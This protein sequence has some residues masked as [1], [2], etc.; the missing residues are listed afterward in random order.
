MS[1]AGIAY[2]SA[3][4]A[5]SRFESGALRPTDLLEA[6]IQRVEVANPLVNAFTELWLDEARDAAAHADARY[7]R[8]DARP[9][10]GV[11]LAVKDSTPLAGKVHTMGSA[12][13]AGNVAERTH[14][15]L[16]R[17]ID[18]GVVMIGRTTM[19]EF[20]EAGNCYTPLWGV[21]RNPWNLHYGPGGSSSGA[22]A[23]LAAGMATI[24][25]GS[26][27][28]GSS[29]I[30]ASCCGVYGYKPP[31][32]RNP[33]TYEGSFDPYLQ[34]GP[35]ARTAADIALM[36]EIIA[37]AS[38]EDIGTLRDTV[39]LPRRSS[40]PAG[41]RIAYS[42][43]LGY[44]NVDAEVRAAFVSTLARLRALGCELVEV[45]LPWTEA[46]YDA[47][48]VMNSIKGTAARRVAAIPDADLTLLS[49]Y[50]ADMIRR[51]TE[52]DPEDVARAIELHVAMYQNL[53]PILE[54]SKVFL[55]PT[56]AVPSIP[57]TQSPLNTDWSIN[58]VPVTPIEAEAWFMT[59]PFNMLSQLPVLSVPIG[60]AS[61]GVPI[62][63]QVVGRSY[64]DA[65]VFEVAYALEEQE[66]EWPFA[67]P[68]GAAI[69]AALP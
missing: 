61:N 66:P 5:I 25:D 8:G 20:G 11:V 58:G 51:G 33:N 57:A 30:P 34:Y 1:S 45:T 17:L 44:F 69:E 16:Q 22:A 53:G 60:Q 29:R 6:I 42:A 41:W 52:S 54:S 35:L 67:L 24:A 46:A 38:V 31:Y 19:P 39:V 59:Y 23:A 21:T 7:E 28:G 47:W 37:G 2:L 10:E 12:L 15:G 50:A 49:D 27:I 13:L 36:Q 62:G 43:D 55:C 63:M 65:D 68:A 9:L 64:Q 48:A 32:G 18:A 14:P 26:D 3:A 4:E 40:D 56:T